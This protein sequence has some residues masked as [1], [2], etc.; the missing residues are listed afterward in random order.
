[1]R[2]KCGT[3][4]NLLIRVL[5][6]YVIQYFCGVSF[7]NW[8]ESERPLIRTWKLTCLTVRQVPLLLNYQTHPH[9]GLRTIDTGCIRM[10]T[11]DW[12]IELD[13]EQFALLTLLSEKKTQRSCYSWGC[14]MF[15]LEFAGTYPRWFISKTCFSKSVCSRGS[16]TLL[17]ASCACDHQP[18]NEHIEYIENISLW[19]VVIME[20]IK[21]WYAN[22]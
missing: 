9:V 12:S 11:F 3:Q 16:L 1:M 6:V 5:H 18:S 22:L 15:V 17:G 10:S 7:K 21:T 13:D 20:Q 14:V 8:S 2:Q 4:F 19:N